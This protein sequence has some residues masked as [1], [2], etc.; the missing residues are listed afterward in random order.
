M[1]TESCNATN[2]LESFAFIG[3]RNTKNC[4]GKGRLL[5]RIERI[6]KQDISFFS[7]ENI[8]LEK[9]PWA[10]FHWKKTISQHVCSYS[11]KSDC[12]LI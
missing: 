7:S 11:K 9:L 6:E 8:L 4:V 2:L 5:I 1:H 3:A 12:D 10:L